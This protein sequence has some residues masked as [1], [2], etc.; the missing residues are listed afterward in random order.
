MQALKTNQ[1][2]LQARRL[3]TALQ[4]G[5]WAECSP[6]GDSWVFVWLSWL[7]GRQGGVAGPGLVGPGWEGVEGLAGL[8]GRVR[9]G[10]VQDGAWWCWW[11]CGDWAGLVVG[12]ACRW[13]TVGGL[14]WTNW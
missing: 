8:V 10:G 6:W 7:G 14:I 2:V 12:R 5:T 9:Q 3:F 4:M 1:V 11:W 13:V